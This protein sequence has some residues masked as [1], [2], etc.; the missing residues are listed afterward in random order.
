VKGIGKAI[1]VV[2]MAHCCDQ[3]AD[4]IYIA[5]LCN[6]AQLGIVYK[7]KHKLRNI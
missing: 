6:A 2:V 1:M 5:Q 7:K 3:G 4:G